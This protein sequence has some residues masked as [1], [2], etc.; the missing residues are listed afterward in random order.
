VNLESNG[1]N[2]QYGEFLNR[3]IKE[4]LNWEKANPGVKLMEKEEELARLYKLYNLAT[5][6]GSPWTVLYLNTI[7]KDWPL[8]LHQAVRRLIKLQES[9][10]WK[11]YSRQERLTYLQEIT[12]MYR[13]DYQEWILL[14][15]AAS[16]GLLTGLMELVK[17][18]RKIKEANY[19]ELMRNP[20]EQARKIGK[21]DLVVGIPFF[22]EAQTIPGVIKTATEGIRRYYADKKAVIITVGDS[23]KGSKA[24]EAADAVKIKEKNIQRI[25][26]LN[27]EELSGKG[28]CMRIVLELAQQLEAP[29][30]FLD[31]DLRSI[32]DRKGI[33]MG[34][35]PETIKWLYQPL[36]EGF[37]Y[38]T[39][40]YLRHKWDG[41]ITNHLCYPLI[42][43]IYGKRIRQPIGGEIAISYRF[44]QIL[45]KN[46]E[47]WFTD[48]GTYGIDNWITSEA[49]VNE[50]KIGESFLTAKVHNPS[51][52]KLEKMFKQV[53]SVLFDQIMKNSAWWT[54]RSTD[55]I[56][57]SLE[58]ELVNPIHELE[59]P[60]VFFDWEG[61]IAEFKKNFANRWQDYETIFSMEV[62]HELKRL[63]EMNQ[64][65]FIFPP[66]LWAKVVYDFLLEYAFCDPL[67]K[68]EF[69][70]EE[71]LDT[72][73]PIYLAR[74][75]SFAKETQKMTT[76]EAEELVR[77]QANEFIRG[78]KSFIDRWQIKANEYAKAH[79]QLHYLTNPEGKRFARLINEEVDEKG[80]KILYLE[81]IEQ[82]E[83]RNT[84]LGEAK[85]YAR[86]LAEIEAREVVITDISELSRPIPVPKV[87]KPLLELPSSPFEEDYLVLSKELAMTH[88][89][90]KALYL[91]PDTRVV[92]IS[93]ADVTS[94]PWTEFNESLI[95]E[96]IDAIVSQA[97]RQNLHAAS[98]L[99]FEDKIKKIAAL[100]HNS[101]EQKFS[102]YSAYPR[103]C[104][105]A[106]L[107]ATEVL[108][109]L[110]YYVDTLWTRDLH[111][112]LMVS[113]GESEL[114]VDLTS[115]QF[116]LNRFSFL[117]LEIELVTALL[118]EGKKEEVNREKTQGLIDEIAQLDLKIRSLPERD[119]L[120]ITL[121]KLRE[122]AC[123]ANYSLGDK[124]DRILTQ[125]L[126]VQLCQQ[127]REKRNSLED[128]YRA[129]V[130]RVDPYIAIRRII[131]YERPEERRGRLRVG[132][133][134]YDLSRV[135]NILVVGAGKVSRRMAEALLDILGERITGG[136]LCLPEK[137]LAAPSLRKKFQLFAGGYPIPN[138]ES[139]KG[140]QKIKLLLQSA[141]EADMVITILS[142][143]AAELMCCPC[144]GLSLRDLQ[145]TV[146][147]LKAASV[148]ISEINTVTK[149][150]DALKGG[151]L[152]RLG[153]RV[154]RFITLVLSDG[155]DLGDEPAIIGGAPTIGDES[156]FADALE[157]LNKYYLLDKV[158]TSVKDFL[159]RGAAN[160][161]PE[162]PRFEDPLFAYEN[163]EYLLVGDNDSALDNAYH[164]AEKLGYRTRVVNKKMVGEVHE[165]AQEILL[166]IK[167]DLSSPFPQAIVLGGKPTVKLNTSRPGQGGRMTML[168]ILLAKGL[169]EEHLDQV[170]IL[171]ADTDGMDGNS[172]IAGGIVDSQTIPLARSLG[173]QYTDFIKHF[174]CAT[175]LKKLG[176]ELSIGNT[177]TDVGDLVVILNHPPTKQN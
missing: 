65:D 21:A 160:L 83:D 44:G 123:K 53:A 54:S 99:Y 119:S 79:S 11:H 124:L 25:S 172:D 154:K 2:N 122:A 111:Y 63:S 73:I 9:T 168:A 98:P 27:L 8:R 106:T 171:A 61:H 89:A 134:D 31:A 157:V 88:P 85:R 114:I 80:R 135:E 131:D 120:I 150:L 75:A 170:T 60:P 117:L 42:A 6:K 37:D 130:V 138:Q 132:S 146:A 40:Y 116:A 64:V 140:A 74:A 56:R 30:I 177:G 91:S 149:H 101:L 147:L 137:E 94:L 19:Q 90:L 112:F 35:Q 48:I 144:E 78:R 46:P 59:P 36:L 95:E 49:I 72:L 118:R 105:E 20:R 166:M 51:E 176:Q 76:L 127:I 155:P 55:Q 57:K 7:L 158:S 10:A 43:A 12:E 159:Q 38:I 153:S 151:K 70:K 24:K 16:G 129:A 50:M 139:V 169:A 175:L 23:R 145:D 81:P 97:K 126:K 163:L 109:D 62:Y 167:R 93:R 84:F 115:D 113:Y 47:V 100:I 66:S 102:K 71:M 28:W 41:T 22:D 108:V 32:A 121:Q 1:Y 13:L 156:T 45:L 125:L 18:E 34:L 110:G 68:E 4:F 69:I 33:I 17:L 128:I 161:V 92:Q 29:V 3:A 165:V 104:A 107:V 148:D 39:P 82:R 152:R 58:I 87:T 67:I 26:F 173:L 86:V 142:S 162:N 15:K 174:D 164:R 14:N 141:G 143:G 96:L 103:L 136:V 77:Q 133:R 52:G 5:Q